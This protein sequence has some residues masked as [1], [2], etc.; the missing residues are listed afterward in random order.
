M[1]ILM[2]MRFLNFS[3]ASKMF[4]WVAKA[5]S[6]IGYNVTIYIFSDNITH[7]P[8]DDISFIHEDLSNKGFI[9]KIH[10]IR[11]VIKKVDADVSIS[12]LLDANVYNTFACIGQRT[13][14]IICERNDP[15]KPQYYKLKFCKP[16][17]YFADGGVF[18]L[19]K[20]AEYYSN[21]R[22]ETAVIP[23]PVTTTS[24]VILKPFEEREKKIVT[25]GRIAIKQKRND[26]QIEAF[27]LFHRKHP[28]YQL[29]IY[30]RSINGDDIKLQKLIKEKN[31]TESV[32]MSGVINNVQEA[33]ENTQIYLL[34]SDYEGIP[35]SL[36]EAMSIGLPCISTDCRPGGASFLIQNGINGLLAPCDNSE[37]LAEKM[38]W[39]VEHPREADRIGE[40]AKNISDVLSENKIKHLWM[41]YLEKLTIQN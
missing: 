12:F 8:E 25:L 17:F 20:V 1:K 22:G 30:G 6:S 27:D 39:L 4:L 32:I 28:D 38:C 34:T 24:K 41:E 23:N 18:Q 36:I 26:L 21:I 35:N 5:L 33:I 37:I 31:L 16:F 7:Q 19:K 29:I 2:L 9:G 11:K 3:G 13:K 40:N 10:S 15:F 14:S